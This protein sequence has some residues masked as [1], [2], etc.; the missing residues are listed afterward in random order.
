MP[1]PDKKE[2]WEELG[3]ESFAKYVEAQDEKTKALAEKIEAQQAEIDKKAEKPVEKT[4]DELD[5]EK[6]AKEEEAEKNKKLTE[7]DYKIKATTLYA[8]LSDKQREE[9]EAT[10]GKLPED[11]QAVA[12][13]SFEAKYQ[14]LADLYPALN[15]DADDGTI[16]GDLKSQKKKVST[17]EL[18]RSAM[19][20]LKGK[21]GNPERRG[22][23]F[24]PNKD[25]DGNDIEESTSAHPD[26]MSGLYG[27]EK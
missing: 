24:V 18:I 9:A 13:T 19:D 20:A 11:V 4:Q 23:G 16:F 25:A 15:E 5:A 17:S 27:M 8:S 26:I 21:G 7:D 12:K 22:S 3:F 10:I 1:E 6:K 14:I 2:P